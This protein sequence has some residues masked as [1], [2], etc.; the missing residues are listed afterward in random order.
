M[1]N[2]AAIL[3]LAI[4]SLANAKDEPRRSPGYAGS[5]PPGQISLAGSSIKC[6][7]INKDPARTRL[8]VP[9]SSDCALEIPSPDGRFVAETTITNRPVLW[10][11]DRRTGER[12]RIRSYEQPLTFRWRPSS[13]EFLLNDGEG[14]GQ[15]SRL[16]YFRHEGRRWHGT[17]A[18]D[19]AAV[20]LYLKRY[21][22]KGGENSYANVSGW[23]WTANGHFRA[24]V[25]EGVHSEGCL[26]P[27]RDRNVMLEVIGDP[28][29]G[30]ITSSREVEELD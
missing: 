29:T 17:R 23:D 10:I 27:Y 26:Q 3:V 5:L 20:A 11:H 18:F 16:I 14:S 25:T 12:R 30:R 21:D 7:D 19:R 4:A 2:F 28:M 9:L 8:A 22:C 15:V 13:T 24:I 1:K 6:A